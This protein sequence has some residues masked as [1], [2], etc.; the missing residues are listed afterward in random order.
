MKRV[1]KKRAS[2]GANTASG[3][4]GAIRIIAG[5]WRGRRLP[6]RHAEGLRPTTDRNKETLFNWL[7]NDITDARCLDM[8]A[9]SGGLGME[10]LSRYAASCVFFEQDRDNVAQLNANLSAL[11]ANAKVYQ[12]DALSLVTAVP[13]SFDL[14][15]IDPPFGQSLVQPALNA[16]FDGQKVTDDTLIYLEQEAQ[17]PLPALPDGWGWLKQKATSS[18]TYGLIGKDG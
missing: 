4:T 7:M 11:K 14:V 5:Q 18:L 9:G 10:A 17:H 13:G 3:K 2:R 8:F 1:P 16:L 12:G 6:V 15:F